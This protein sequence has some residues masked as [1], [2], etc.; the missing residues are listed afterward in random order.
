MENRSGAKFEAEQSKVAY[1]SS[2]RLLIIL[3]SLLLVFGLAIWNT[4]TNPEFRSS[5]LGRED[6]RFVERLDYFLKHVATGN[7]NAVDSAILNEIRNWGFSEGVPIAKSDCG[8]TGAL[9]WLFNSNESRLP[10]ND[11]LQRFSL[12]LRN[13]TF[14]TQSKDVDLDAFY[15][16]QVVLRA[17]EGDSSVLARAY[18]VQGLSDSTLEVRRKN[19]GKIVFRR[20]LQ[21]QNW[22]PETRSEQESWLQSL[23]AVKSFWLMYRDS[24]PS[25]E[26]RETMTISKL[27]WL[28]RFIDERQPPLQNI[29]L[30]QGIKLGGGPAFLVL[31]WIVLAL[32][33]LIG[34]FFEQ[35]R[36]W[37]SLIEP[38]AVE[39]GG[40]LS[41]LSSG[42]F[43]LF[44]HF[45]SSRTPEIGRASCR[46]R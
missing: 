41:S 6:S 16:S 43:H 31:P 34:W 27:K 22:Y 45:L 17:D 37:E 12:G 5:Q 25:T 30:G 33:W 19:F 21:K 9:F 23:Y 13:S 7:L 4:V 8:E 29:E 11:L 20:I 15:L 18:F 24:L 39:A 35:G 1:R 26:D 2:A 10:P 42:Y 36:I 38:G 40:N 14:S 28:Y 46:E 3:E 32:S 44:D